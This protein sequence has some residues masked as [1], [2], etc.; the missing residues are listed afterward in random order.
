MARPKLL[1]PQDY[2]DDIIE[3]IQRARVRISILAMMIVDDETTSPLIDALEAAARRGVRVKM[4]ADVFTYAELSGFI[5]PTRYRTS[6]GRNTNDTIKRL[7]KA[8]VDFTWLGTQSMTLLNGRTHSKWSVIDDTI[9]AFGGVNLYQQGVENTDYMFRIHDKEIAAK[10]WHEY[11]A[12]M[13]ANRQGYN[14]HSHFFT[15]E[16]GTVLIDSGMFNNSLIYKRTCELAEQAT[17]VILISQYCPTG[18]LS[19]ILKQK[20]SRLYFNPPIL[21]NRM[22]RILI[23]TSM[24]LTGNA[25]LY[26]RSNYLHAKLVLFTMPDGSEVAITG[27]HNFVHSASLLGTREIAL[28]TSNPAVIS[29]L[30]AFAEA[31]VFSRGDERTLQDTRESTVRP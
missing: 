22:N 27:S 7:K 13:H 26:T 10:L 18:K 14:Y 25:S 9:Y 21:A 4:A 5:L 17:S 24:M 29:Q 12:I 23:A 6:V 15:S 3:K 31:R 20:E 2:I 19:R 16:I 11:A 30:K 28:E 8:G 1:L